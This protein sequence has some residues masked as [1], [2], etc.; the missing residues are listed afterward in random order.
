M[1]HTSYYIL[2]EKRVLNLFVF[3][4]EKRR[5]FLKNPRIFFSGKPPILNRSVLAFLVLTFL[6]IKIKLAVF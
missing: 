3:S 5:I 2:T 1:I 6:S 4:D